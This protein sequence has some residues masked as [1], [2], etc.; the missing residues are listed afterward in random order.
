M[1]VFDPLD[2]CGS[3]VGGCWN[4]LKLISFHQLGHHHCI[5]SRLTFFFFVIF[6]I[7]YINVSFL[8]LIGYTD[9]HVY[10]LIQIPFKK[11]LTE[12]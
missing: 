11:S 1:L 9:I 12:H 10:G 6:L 7:E 5:L 4:L 3:L 8:N 2:V